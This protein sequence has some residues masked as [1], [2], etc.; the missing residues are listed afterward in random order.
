MSSWV[1]NNQIA[2]G[3]QNLERNVVYDYVNNYYRAVYH[4]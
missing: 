2:R 3:E 1:I 4:V